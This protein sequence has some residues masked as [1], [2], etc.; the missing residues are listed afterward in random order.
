M[1]VY[2]LLLENCCVASSDESLIL[3][4]PNQGQYPEIVNITVFA[5]STTN[6]SDIVL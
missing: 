1:T 3:G 5:E 4:S 2:I 6:V